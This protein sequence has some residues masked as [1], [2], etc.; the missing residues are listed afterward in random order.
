MFRAF[1]F[2]EMPYPHLPGDDSFESVRVSLPNEL[3]DPEIGYQLYEKYF[4]IYRRADELGL[5]IMLNEHHSTATC[6]PPS[7]ATESSP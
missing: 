1:V 3:Y 2:T 6:A 4:D 5:D 7:C